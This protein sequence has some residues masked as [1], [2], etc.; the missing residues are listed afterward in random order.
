MWLRRH[1]T[2]QGVT[3][4]C[5]HPLRY[6]PTVLLHA[7][8]TTTL[9]FVYLH[10]HSYTCKIKVLLDVG[11][12]HTHIRTHFFRYILMFYLFIHLLHQKPIFCTDKTSDD[13]QIFT[14]QRFECSSQLEVQCMLLVK[15]KLDKTEWCSWR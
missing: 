7:R 13:N 9:L 3:S 14:G 6:V 12:E 1:G 5:S 4:R 15:E 11:S 2:E 8:M 10:A